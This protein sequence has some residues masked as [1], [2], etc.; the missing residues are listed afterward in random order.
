MILSDAFG[1]IL[2]L[3]FP[4]D[5]IGCGKSGG[6][7]LCESCLARIASSPSVVEL[8]PAGD[9]RERSSCLKGLRAAGTYSGVLKEL[10]LGLKSH[11]KP[12]AFPLARLMVAAAGNDPDYI[13]PDAICY[14]PSERAK[15]RERGHNPAELL[16]DTIS[17][18]LGVPVAHCLEKT[19]GT[20][21]Q[22]QLPAALRWDN[23]SGAFRCVPGS[24]ARGSVLLIDDVLTTGTTIRACAEPLLN[25][26]VDAVHVLVAAR[27]VLR[28]GRD[29][30]HGTDRAR[31]T[32]RT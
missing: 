9:S 28:R 32:L 24:R 12:F 25:D 2:D 1:Q 3:V 5:C 27:A 26:G 22:D 13:S 15:V 17:K 19:K 16:A 6:K 29:T 21:D 18:L 4:T 23:V 7:V 31:R 11:G 10:V 14:V 30:S 8:D 20:R